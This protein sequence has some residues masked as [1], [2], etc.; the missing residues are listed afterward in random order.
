MGNHEQ[1]KIELIKKSFELRN[2]KKY[3]SAIEM[4]YKVLEFQNDTQDSI[5]ILSQLGDLSVLMNNFDRA[6]E[7]FQKALSMNPNHEYCA[8]QCFEIYFKTNQLNKAL[9][10]A[11]G[12][13]ENAKSSKSFYNHIKTLIAMDKKQDAIEVFNMLDE[14]IKMDVDILY[15][16][17]GIDESKKEVI[18]KKILELDLGHVDANI[19]LALIEFDKGNYDKVIP[20]C[21]NIDEDNAL[22]L[23]LLAR[24]EASK[25]NYSRAIELYLKAIELDNDEHDFYLDLAKT[26]IDISWFNE[27]LVSLKKSINLSVAKNNLENIDEKY[28]LS[29]WILIKKNELSKALLNLE[30]INKDS[31]LYSK[32]QILA[33]VVNI[34]KTDI[35]SA[36]QKL[37][38]FFKEEQENGI[39]IDTLAFCYKELK[40]YNKAIDVYKK[41]L[42]NYPDSIYY[43]LEIIDLL[44]DDKKYNEALDLIDD[45]SK[46]YQ[47][48][49]NIYNSLARIFYR[50][51]NYEKALVSIE[52]YFKLDKNNPETYYFKGLILND[53]EQFDEAKKVIYTAIKF[54]P[55]E[56][57][58]Y[59]QMARAYVGLKEYE[60]ALLYAKEAIEINQGEINY[61]KQAYD[62][63][64]LIGDVELVKRY[65]AQ[66]IRSEKILKSER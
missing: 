51:K 9:R 6:L 13:C 19:G 58:Y 47:N 11:L 42:K 27:A 57:K 55:L 30:S 38:L 39:L 26:Y 25:K 46:I 21:L 50:M 31:K 33:Q 2:Q 56:A 12:M 32:A 43:T 63:S 62:I 44:I 36:I 41:G 20:Y 1:E 53:I 22:A 28:F 29:A 60:N 3:K 48:C 18:L 10:V 35:S 24:I 59:S 61:K 23:Y 17:S 14:Q 40:M 34:K 65:Q 45:F 49:P 52:E 64:V 7:H 66:L 54:N 37:E 16:I 8:Q 15:L 4:L 5:E